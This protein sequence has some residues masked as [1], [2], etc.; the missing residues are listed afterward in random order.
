MT[1]MF[2]V[3]LAFESVSQPLSLLA[4]YNDDVRL[5]DTAKDIL[6]NGR[7]S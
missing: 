7:W 6:Y 2:M 4:Y 5:A 1:K 3:S